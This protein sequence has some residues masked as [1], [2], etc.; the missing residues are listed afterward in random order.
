MEAELALGDQAVL[1]VDQPANSDDGEAGGFCEPTAEVPRSNEAQEGNVG[2]TISGLEQL[3]EEPG[4]EDVVQH[5]EQRQQEG[6]NEK[7][8]NGGEASTEGEY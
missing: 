2:E 3:G 5:L 7:A 1:Q 8:G 4:I 6:A